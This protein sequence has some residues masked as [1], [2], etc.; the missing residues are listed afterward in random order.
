VFQETQQ[1]EIYAESAPGHAML[2]VVAGRLLNQP[3]ALDPLLQNYLVAP[4]GPDTL[5][6]LTFLMHSLPDAHT[7]P[8]TFTQSLRVRR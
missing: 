8:T 3:N 5:E 1:R 2:W 4:P 6:D 7:I